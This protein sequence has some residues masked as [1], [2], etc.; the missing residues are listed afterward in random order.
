V[1]YRTAFACVV[2]Y[3]E[4]NLCLNKK[5]GY[6]T[7]LSSRLATGSLKKLTMIQEQT[8]RTSCSLFLASGSRNNENILSHSLSGARAMLLESKKRV[9]LS[10]AQVQNDDKFHVRE[11]ISDVVP[12]P[13]LTIDPV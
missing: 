10:F 7:V 6:F 11:P 9:Q 13:R 8:L 12:C 4:V 1:E 3:L 2:F 5:Q